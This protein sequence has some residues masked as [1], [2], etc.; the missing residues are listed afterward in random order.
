MTPGS[1]RSPS[2]STGAGTLRFRSTGGDSMEI[3]ASSRWPADESQSN[4]Y[5]AKNYAPIHE[6]TETAAPQITQEPGDYG[7]AG[8]GTDQ[9]SN[10]EIRGEDTVQ[11]GLLVHVVEGL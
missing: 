11:P 9:D 6:G 1:R 7:A 3:R 8:Q 10:D 4:Y 2:P 5:Y